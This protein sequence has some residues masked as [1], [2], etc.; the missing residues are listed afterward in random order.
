MEIISKLIIP[1]IAVLGI[2]VLV[3]LIFISIKLKE[4]S[5]VIDNMLYGTKGK[6]YRDQKTLDLKQRD[7][8]ISKRENTYPL[9]KNFDELCAKYL[10]WAQMIPIFPL[11]GILGTVTGLIHQVNTQEATQIYASLDEALLTTLWGLVAAIVLK[12]VEAWFVQREINNIETV[13]NDYDIKYQD[14]VDIKSSEEN[15]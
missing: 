3:A 10:V 4:L 7:T 13:F 6:I 8:A 12:I 9:R 15:A 1:L 11:L 14:A 5:R 2:A